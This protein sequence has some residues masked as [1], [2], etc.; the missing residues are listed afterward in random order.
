MHYPPMSQPLAHPNGPLF[1]PQPHSAFIPMQYQSNNTAGVRTSKRKP[2]NSPAGEPAPR[3]RQK[4]AQRAT[5]DETGPT[6]SA[7]ASADA[8][9][10]TA[11]VAGVGPIMCNAPNAPL[12]VVPP[13]T[14]NPSQP[15]HN[16]PS[17][18]QSRWLNPNSAT[19]PATDVWHFVLAMTPEDYALSSSQRPWPDLEA[20][21]DLKKK[22]GKPFTHVACKPCI[23]K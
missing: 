9:S 16:P 12:V 7:V 2:T 13:P 17:T 3:R 18:R 1:P 6:I 23:A 19:A 15:N 11:S 22:P 5:V 21:P 4:S 14:I 20:K 8:R 10:M